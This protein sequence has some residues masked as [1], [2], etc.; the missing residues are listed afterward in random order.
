MFHL[1]DVIRMGFY[2]SAKAY[3]APP[4]INAYWLS[5]TVIDPIIAFLLLKKSKVGILLG[6]INILLNVIINSGLAISTLS[7]FSVKAIYDTLGN[8]YNGLQ[9]ALLT[10]SVLSLPIVISNKGRYFEVFGKLPFLVLIAGLV[11][12]LSGL[13]KLFLHF[14]TLWILWVHSSMVIIDGALVYL[15]FKKLKIAYILGLTLFGSFGI[16]Q[17]GFAFAIFMGIECSFNLAMS[18]TISICFLSFAGLMLNKEKFTVQV[19]K[20]QITANKD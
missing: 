14:E 5:L 9:I 11:I 2:N 10:F 19:L 12:H 6:F 4:A 18:V 13:F 8:I 3:G 7:T 16:L 1:S 17:T 20:K 15:L